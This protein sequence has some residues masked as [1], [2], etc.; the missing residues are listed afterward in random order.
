MKYIPWILAGLVLTALFLF[1]WFSRKPFFREPHVVE[2][3][4]SRISPLEEAMASLDQ[5]KSM[6]RNDPTAV[7][8]YYSGLN[9]CLRIYLNRQLGLV[10]MEKTSEELILS[11]SSMRD[12]DIFSK[13]ADCPA[14]GRFCKVCEICSRAL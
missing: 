10:T 2:S 12:R 8:K 1:I 11:L 9:D 4:K 3:P 6:L 13:L 7:K 5:L 14:H